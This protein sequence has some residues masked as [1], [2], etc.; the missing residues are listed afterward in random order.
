[1]VRKIGLGKD[2]GG[3]VRCGLRWNLLFVNLTFA[4]VEQDCKCG[5]LMISSLVVYGDD[6][7]W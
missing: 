5:R 3:S 4:A 6:R 2:A 1:M 7:D